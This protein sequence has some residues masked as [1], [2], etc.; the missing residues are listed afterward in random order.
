MSVTQSLGELETAWVNRLINDANFA[1]LVGS[2]GGRVKLLRGWPA[3]VIQQ[4]SRNALPIVTYLRA[5]QYTLGTDPPRLDIQSDIWCWPDP[6]GEG[7]DQLN[8]I[9]NA[10]LAL[11]TDGDSAVRWRDD[12]LEIDVTCVCTDANEP[13]ENG[14]LRRRRIWELAVG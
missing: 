10:M 11:L 3:K 2:S 4:P 7:I 9:D 12:E 6:A 5:T 14:L 1:G 8:A 13:Q